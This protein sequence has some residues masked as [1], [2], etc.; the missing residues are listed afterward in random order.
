LPVLV[1]AL[2]LPA[3]SSEPEPAPPATTDTVVARYSDSTRKVV[4]VRRTQDDSLIERRYYRQTG[5]L[6]RVKRGDSVA[7]YFDL[8]DPDSAR[9]LQDY[10]QGR[11]RN[12]SAAMSDPGASAFYI[13]EGKSLTFRNP[14]GEPLETINVEYDNYRRIVTGHGDPFTADIAD[15]DTVRVTGYTLVREDSTE[16]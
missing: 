6:K 8:H 1:A 3:C 10:M 9:V 16:E 5:A 12:A 14:S 15:F 11:W 7:E 13:F 2:F 4:E